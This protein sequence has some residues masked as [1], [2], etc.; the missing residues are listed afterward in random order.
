MAAALE[1]TNIKTVNFSKDWNKY[2][3]FQAEYKS[4][5]DILRTEGREVP[6][7]VNAD[8]NMPAIPFQWT[9]K[10]NATQPR[11]N[12]KT[13]LS[14]AFD[15]KRISEYERHNAA[16]EKTRKLPAHLAAPHLIPLMNQ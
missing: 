5:L 16:F 13:D 10:S 7:E 2:T 1:A 3:E 15:D 6:T 12:F 14:C 4:R 8:R 11:A 9:G